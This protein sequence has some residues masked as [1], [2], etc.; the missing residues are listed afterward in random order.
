MSNSEALST[1]E[2]ADL[3]TVHGGIT[4]K[5]KGTVILPGGAGQLEGE[6][7]DT[8]YDRCASEA[9]DAA[10]TAY[11]DNRW[12]WQRWLGQPDPNARGRADYKMEKLR[13]CPTG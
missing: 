9:S 8:P 7:S 6:Y 2:L 1:I 13:Q 4:V 11:P 3:I 10:S 5:G 12:F